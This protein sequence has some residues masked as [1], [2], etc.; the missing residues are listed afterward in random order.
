MP[1]KLLSSTIIGLNEFSQDPLSA[2]QGAEQGT[3]AVFNNNAPVMYALTAE[4]L[5]EL[6]A[7]EAAVRQPADVALDEQFFEPQPAQ[8]TTFRAPA[9]K[10]PMYSGWQPDADFIRQAALWGIA[11]S[12]PVSEE[13]LASF[14]AYWQAEGRV[15]HHVQWQ[16]KL[17]R[18]LQTGRVT[19][20]SSQGR[21]DLP[22]IAEPDR[23]TPNGFRGE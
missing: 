5:A 23:Q 15:F 2:L 9:G 12:E 7:A 22:G 17:A 20:Y 21:R 3:L 6:L 16:Q 11:L 4:R 8:V 14:T 10:F 13:E 18:S 19:K 1:V